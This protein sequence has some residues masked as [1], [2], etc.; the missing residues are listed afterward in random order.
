MPAYTTADLRYAYEW[1]QA[2]FS[3]GVTNLM[4]R[5]FYTL[6]FACAAGQPTSVYPEPGR[7]F[8]AAR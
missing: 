8:T 4:D 5:K 2:E 6:A 3:A 7:A 1:K